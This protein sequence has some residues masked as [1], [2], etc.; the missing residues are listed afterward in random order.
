MPNLNAALGLAQLEM[1]EDFIISKRD[2]ALKYQEW[3]IKNNLVFIKEQEG[4]KSNYWLNCLMTED[5]HERDS[6]LEYTNSNNV[7]TRPSWTPLH[8][9]GMYEKNFK[10]DLKDTV[11]VHERLINLPSSP[12]LE[13][14]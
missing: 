14:L 8:L 11:W 6:L 3:G 7:M 2:I 9:L 12:I 4:S 1:I 5:R 13:L 10:S